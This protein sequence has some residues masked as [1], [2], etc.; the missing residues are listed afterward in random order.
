M[1]HVLFGLAI[2]NKYPVQ[3]LHTVF[4]LLR[5]S[6][7][8]GLAVESL[9]ATNKDVR[10]TKLDHTNQL[11]VSSPLEKLGFLLSLFFFFCPPPYRQP[12]RDIAKIEATDASIRHLLARASVKPDGKPYV[13]ITERNASV[14]D[15]ASS[16]G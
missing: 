13:P 3:I 15:C 16:A 11:N 8:R 6:T 2:R 14:T 7:P 12:S 9:E 10:S 1:D 5:L 4:Q